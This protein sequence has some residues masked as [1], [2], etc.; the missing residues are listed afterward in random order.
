MD[1]WPGYQII[2]AQRAYNYSIELSSDAG[3]NW[4][5]LGTKNGFR[6]IGSVEVFTFASIITGL[7]SGNNFSIRVTDLNNTLRNAISEQ[8]SIIPAISTNLKVEF[9][10]DYSFPEY[11]QGNPK[12]IAADGLGRIYFKLSKINPNIGGQM[13]SV[14]IVLSDGISSE[15]KVLG[16]VMVATVID[17]Y[18]DEANSANS[19]EVTDNV[20]RDEYWFWYV[21]PDDFVRSE[22]MDGLKSFR[23]VTSTFTIKYEG[24]AQEVVEEEIKIVRPP[25][26]LVHGLSG[27]ANTWKNFAWVKEIGKVYLKDDPRFLVRNII[28]LES[29]LSFSLNSQRL[30]ASTDPS[31]IYRTTLKM[32]QE[33][34]ACNQVYYVGHSMGGNLVRAAAQ[35]YPTNFYKN[36]QKGCVNRIITLDTPH[37][38]SPLAD[39]V[40]EYLPALNDNLLART[41]LTKMHGDFPNFFGFNYIEPISYSQWIYK[42]KPTGS[43]T[44]LRIN[45]GFQHQQTNI[46]TH[47]IACDF[48]PGEQILPD[49]NPVIWESL[50]LAEKYVDFIDIFFDVVINSSTVDVNL[51]RQLK[52]LRWLNK[53]ERVVKFIELSLQSYVALGFV[54]ESDFV[55][56]VNSQLAGLPR[57]GTFNRTIFDAYTHFSWLPYPVTYSNEV[58][59]LVYELINTSIYDAKFAQIPSSPNSTYRKQNVVSDNHQL[60]IDSTGISL[61]SPVRGANVYVDSTIS[62][63]FS[64]T[65]T[66]N[67]SYVKVNFQN[68]SITDTTRNFLYNF[69]LQVNG[70]VIDSQLVQIA[71]IK[72]YPDST[73]ILTTTAMINI[74]TTNPIIDFTADPLIQTLILNQNVYPEYRA[75]FSNFISSIGNKSNNITAIVND[76]SIIEFDPETK[77]FKAISNGETCAI[78][79]YGGLS[80]TIY[81]IVD[82]EEIIP[83]APNLVSPLDQSE[84]FYKNIN[85]VW[86][87]D[88]R[89]SEYQLQ[90]STNLNFTSIVF[91]QNIIMDTTYSF[92][93]LF[94][95]N[96]YYWRVRSL[97]YVGISDWSEVWSFNTVDSLTVLTFQLTANIADGWNMVSTPGLHPVDQ[98]VTTWWSG[99]DPAAGVFRFSGGYLPVT[100]TTPG[101]GY[102]MKHVG[103]NTYKTGGEWPAAESR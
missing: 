14:S 88:T 2:G 90:L 29:N 103:A 61:I 15:T 37:K 10:W 34:Y 95:D 84:V 101:Q 97:N 87:Q 32:K 22:I 62:I 56:G 28:T 67:L 73:V 20:A 102:W 70:N 4:N 3:N 12:G 30:L 49:V 77:S 55:V 68:N 82:G 53:A 86:N 75:V 83:N 100:T 89:A 17:T 57:D 52:P 65:D 59:N 79:S 21:S 18:S 58:G 51:K 96:T 94:I 6:R 44:D 50:E 8:F 31:S 60:R 41:S 25:L 54:L 33:G 26:M 91:E 66:T 43:I 7:G 39:L 64:I 36:Y 11:R 71:A 69:A 1:P 78:I 5:P 93:S 19:I 48:F 13:N 76:P 27:N 9:C 24:G 38:G 72:E 35:L 99:K 80:D 47:L 92:D 85:L 42:F 40:E 46:P 63:K 81:F 23:K 74:S 45:N 16:K 98:N